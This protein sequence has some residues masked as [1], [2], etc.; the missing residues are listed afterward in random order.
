MQTKRHRFLALVGVLV[1]LG[2]VGAPLESG[3]QLNLLDKKFDRTWGDYTW[4]TWGGSREAARLG[5]ED[6][7]SREGSCPTGGCVL[8]LDKV[9]VLPPRG[10]QGE[11]LTLITTYTI[12]TPEQVAL[13]IA[14]T[15]EIF[16]QGKS[17]GRT[18]SMETRRENGTWSQEVDFTL[19]ANAVPGTY[20][21]NTRVS[22]G[23]G[24]EAK[25][26][27]FQVY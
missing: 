5:R 16:F 18:K 15:R 19:P 26:V 21:L 10:R 13:P 22:T 20:T 9:E 8:R 25:T 27:D 1:L 6:L 4:G 2:L 14:I 11:T 3:A 12:L 24:Q 17:L 23:Y 7:I